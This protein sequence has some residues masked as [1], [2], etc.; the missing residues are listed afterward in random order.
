MSFLKK[1]GIVL[2]NVAT[3]A[4][5]IGPIVAP[6]FGVGG[7]GKVTGVIGTVTNDL[8]MIGSLIAQVE[9]IYAGQDGTGAQKLKAAIA[10]VGPVIRTSQL[11]SGKKIADPALMQK[12]IDE[13][14][15]GVADIL[16]SLHA[17]SVSTE[18]HTG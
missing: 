15:Q 17:D 16:N 18:I 5:G 14:T 1:L 12:G 13:V 7:S 9:T 4:I 2:A 3:T 8:T 10:L 11:V 6:L